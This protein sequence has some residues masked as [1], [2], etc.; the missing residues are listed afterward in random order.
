MEYRYLTIEY[1]KRFYEE[2]EKE[3]EDALNLNKE[4]HNKEKVMKDYIND[5]FDHFNG[6]RK[7]EP[8]FSPYYIEQT[9]EQKKEAQE[10]IKQLTGKN[11]ED[12][13]LTELAQIRTKLEERE[14]ELEK[15]FGK[16]IEN[17]KSET[18]EKE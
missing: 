12:L 15:D 1:G 6:G 13:K 8:G 17:M 16:K 3:I 7:G 5:F 18:Q 4:E 11:V 10:F 14:T 9:E 2:H